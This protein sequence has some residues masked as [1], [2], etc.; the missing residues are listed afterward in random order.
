MLNLI[1]T[2]IVYM[3]KDIYIAKIVTLVLFSLIFLFYF[4]KFIL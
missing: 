2:Y 3:N 1:Y 4:F